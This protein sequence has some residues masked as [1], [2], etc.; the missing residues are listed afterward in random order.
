MSTDSPPTLEESYILESTN[1]EIPPPLRKPFHMVIVDDCQGTDIYSLAKRYL[2]NHVTIQPRQIPITICYLMQSWSGL[3]TVIRLN[4][5][6][7]SIYKT[8]DLKKLKQIYENF[9]TYVDF[10]EFM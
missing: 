2:M 3:P 1:N 10:D 7:F 6:Q 8:G 4:A 5:T 9:A